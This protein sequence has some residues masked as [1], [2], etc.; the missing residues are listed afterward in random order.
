MGTKKLVSVRSARL[1][2]QFLCLQKRWNLCRQIASLL[3]IVARVWLKLSFISANK[4]S[5]SS[6]TKKCLVVIKRSMKFYKNN[7]RKHHRLVGLTWC[8]SASSCSGSIFFT[9]LRHPWITMSIADYCFTIPGVVRRSASCLLKVQRQVTS[10]I[11][12]LWRAKLTPNLGT[13]T[14][15][16][17]KA[18][19][20][21]AFSP[22]L[23]DH[24]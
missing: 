5:N 15:F 2:R 23:A 14:F 18:P 10:M 16:I 12:G 11:L 1:L 9:V 13:R 21:V 24:R 20:N 8:N 7:P 4:S 22:S 3:D 17:C 6:M 19:T